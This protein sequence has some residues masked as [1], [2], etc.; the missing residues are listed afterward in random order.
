[1]TDVEKLPKAN[2]IA[3]ALGH[4]RELHPDITVRQA[5]VLFR[6]AGNPGITQRELQPKTA[7]ECVKHKKSVINRIVR[8]LSEAEVAPGVN[9]FGLVELRP[10]HKDRREKHI[11]LTKKG[12]RLVANILKDTE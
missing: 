12:Y 6:I 10:S 7:S 4:L 11:Y 8:V 5:I 1:M 9:G 2:R 3:S